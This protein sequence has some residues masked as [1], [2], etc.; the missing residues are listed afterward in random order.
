MRSLPA[1]AAATV[2][3]SCQAPW[4]DGERACADTAYLDFPMD[5]DA[6]AVKG[7]LWPFGLHGGNHPEGHPGIDFILDSADVR[8]D[9]PIIA[10]F[11]AVIISITP[12][13]DFPGNSCIVL[14]S[15]CVEVNLCHVKLDPALKEGG[16]VKRGQKLGTLGLLTGEGRY[17]LHFGAYSGPDAK[18]VCPA[19]FLDPKTVRCRLGL[20]TGDKAP[21]D[22]GYAPGTVT[23][24]GRSE[25]D[26]RFSREL[27]VTCADGTRH[28]FA[29]PEE[30][31]LCNARLSKADKARMETCLGNACAGV[32]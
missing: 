10:S 11:S 23:L 5:L 17:S 6:F 22:C 3:L 15:A 18:V 21:E 12:E 26:E 31:S 28:A 24:M 20:A 19:D 7:R 14:D 16:S 25:Y 32:W 9:I 2:L 4:Q 13:T 29:F 30:A 8:G 1:L 27:S